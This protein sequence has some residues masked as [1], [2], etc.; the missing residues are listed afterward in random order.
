[1]AFSPCCTEGN[2][3]PHTNQ[4]LNHI[5]DCVAAHRPQTLYAEYPVSP[6]SYDAG[7]RKITY[8]MLANAINRI[9]WWLHDNLGPGDGAETLAY[10]GPNDLT[11]PALILGAVKAGY[12][13]N[14]IQRRSCVQYED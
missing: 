2:P 4:L 10:I 5:V 14:T 3:F 1:M 12:K 6:V 9:A 8:G 11:Y 7:F 13:V